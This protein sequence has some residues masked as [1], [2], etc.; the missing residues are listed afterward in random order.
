MAETEVLLRL[1]DKRGGYVLP[2]VHTQPPHT[3]PLKDSVMSKTY[4]DLGRLEIPGSTRRSILNP[5]P[6]PKDVGLANTQRRYTTAPL[7]MP[8]YALNELDSVSPA[9]YSVTS[10]QQPTRNTHG[11]T[12]STPPSRDLV[13]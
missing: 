8:M 9:A 13:P 7:L 6:F 12:Y 4:Q 3:T 10:M 11:Q 5:R 2:C 1:K